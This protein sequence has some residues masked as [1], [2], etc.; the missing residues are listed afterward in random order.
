MDL[1]FKKDITD[2]LPQGWLTRKDVY[3]KLKITLLFRESLTTLP[4]LLRQQLDDTEIYC[5]AF[6][7]MPW[8]AVPH[9]AAVVQCHDSTRDMHMLARSVSRCLG[10]GVLA[11]ET[12]APEQHHTNTDLGENP[13][14]TILRGQ[15]V[16]EW[17]WPAKRW[18]IPPGA[19]MNRLA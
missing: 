17:A 7:A 19:L 5:D 1:A 10:P 4:S 18:C 14:Y 2:I 11:I 9:F 12:C 16:G 3:D 6:M 8:A 15:V 13:Y